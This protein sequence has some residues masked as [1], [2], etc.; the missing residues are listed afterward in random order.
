[1]GE[2][3]TARVAD[4]LRRWLLGEH[5]ETT[6]RLRR[7]VEELRQLVCDPA[8]LRVRV[9][10]ALHDEVTAAPAG[11]AA[12]LAPVVDD[13]IR[14]RTAPPEVPRRGRRH[15]PWLSAVAA[16][17]MA[18]LGFLMMWQGG[19][20]AVSASAEQ[21]ASPAPSAVPARVAIAEER[22]DGFGLGQAKL[23]DEAL[24][25]EVRS[26]L[27]ACDELIGASVSFSVKDG[28]VWLRGEATIAGREAASRALAGLGEGVLVVNQ[29]TVKPSPNAMVMR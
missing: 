25:R 19:G 23:S 6:E 9:L 29:L 27:A 24:A 3:N 12:A 22:S 11:V 21:I 5:A 20:A 28:W 2:R 8:V 7:E 26:R 10:A 17:C 1:M 18:G 14:Q 16:A 15:W 13:M 4:R